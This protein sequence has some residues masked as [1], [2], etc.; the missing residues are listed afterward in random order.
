MSWVKSRAEFEKA[1]K[2]KGYSLDADELGRYY[3]HYLQEAWSIFVMI[4]LKA[5]TQK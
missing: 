2:R 5:I 4:D 3:D 1:A